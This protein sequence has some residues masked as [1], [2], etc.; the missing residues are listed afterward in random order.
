MQPMLGV[1][2]CGQRRHEMIDRCC[3][4]MIYLYGISVLREKYYTLIR[5]KNL[6]QKKNVTKE[7][8]RGEAGPSLKN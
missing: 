3:D 2:N 7:R 5:T 8:E 4:L 6:F 1:Y